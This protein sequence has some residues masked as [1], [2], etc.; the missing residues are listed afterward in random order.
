MP[1]GSELAE[2]EITQLLGGPEYRRLFVVTRQRLEQHGDGAK[3]LTLNGLLPAEQ[4]A[5]ASL[6][7]L[8]RLPGGKLRLSLERLDQALRASRLAVGL[9][10]VLIHLGGPLIDR[11][12]VRA[13]ADQRE[14]AMW[15][16][17]E[18]HPALHRHPQLGVWLAE[19]RARGLLRRAA[20]A[21]GRRQEDL[22]R[23]ALALVARLPADGVLLQVLAS[24]VTGDAH[25]LD[26]GQPLRSLFTRAVSLLC[27]MESAPTSAG[28]QRQ[29]LARVGVLCDPLSCDVLVLGLRPCGSQLLAK[30]LRDWAEVGEP[31]RLTLRELVG[32]EV[33]LLPGTEVFVCENPGIV[34]AAADRL[35]SRCAPLLC[36]DGV[37][38]TAVLRLIEQLRAE[39]IHV[40]SDFDWAGLRI[41]NQ[42]CRY[43]GAVPWRMSTSDYLA[44]LPKSKEEVSLKGHPVPASWDASLQASMQRAGRALFEE[45]VMEELLSELHL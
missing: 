16:A 2:A 22:L 24:E 15:A 6:L 38:S 9:R 29:L 31:R 36:T 30:H 13:A 25:A 45:L 14:G 20:T 7:G 27:E 4:A 1:A 40:H 42:L 10:E 17:A 44:T 8:A 5:L 32:A 12:A 37:P 28:E 33:R 18:A 34:A 21:T 23:S 19:L 3:S 35:G 26:R 39:R 43:P 41:A 11:R